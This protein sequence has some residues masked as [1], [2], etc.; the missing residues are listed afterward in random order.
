MFALIIITYACTCTRAIY[1][2]NCL[3]KDS[4]YQ[5]WIIFPDSEMN[6]SDFKAT[7][8]LMK[9]VISS[10]LLSFQPQ[11]Y[12]SFKKAMS[13]SPEYNFQYYQQLKIQKIKACAV[14]PCKLQNYTARA[15]TLSFTLNFESHNEMW[16]IS[17][18]LSPRNHIGLACLY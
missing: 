10:W 14:H 3:Y 6:G 8:G 2:C 12:C 1:N 13:A 18:I 5:R 15:A 11:L 4:G 16:K 7:H 9:Q 17:L